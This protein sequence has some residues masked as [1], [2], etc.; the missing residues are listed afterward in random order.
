MT[1]AF[2]TETAHLVYRSTLSSENNDR[3]QGL[4][5]N[6]MQRKYA[7]R[8]QTA[9][10]LQQKRSGGAVRAP[11]HTYSAP[12]WAPIRSKWTQ[13]KL[14]WL[15][16]KFFCRCWCVLVKGIVSFACRIQQLTR[17]LGAKEIFPGKQLQKIGNS[18]LPLNVQP[19]ELNEKRGFNIKLFISASCSSAIYH[20]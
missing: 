16:T 3:T 7:L 13:R 14:T 11:S 1:D 15:K 2:S 19:K 8:A 20:C 18:C 17:S 12:I 9:E 6:I 10:Q 4:E 5:S